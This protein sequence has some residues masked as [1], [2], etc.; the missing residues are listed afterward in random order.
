MNTLLEIFHVFLRILYFLWR[1]YI[2]Q[3][4]HKRIKIRSLI[5]R[6]DIVEICKSHETEVK[7]DFLW[8][9]YFSYTFRKY[10]TFQI[11]IIILSIC[12]IE[13]VSFDKSY[14]VTTPWKEIVQSINQNLFSSVKFLFSSLVFFLSKILQIITAKTLKMSLLYIYKNWSLCF[15]SLRPW[16]FMYDFFSLFYRTSIQSC[17]CTLL[18]IVLN[19][20]MQEYLRKKMNVALW[21]Y[22]IL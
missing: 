12:N 9:S 3:F 14:D 18:N 21:K 5:I 11:I 16:N 8:K 15:A 20:T 1:F 2:F 7:K 10:N 17:N 22:Y 6:P 19:Y 13:R 4:H